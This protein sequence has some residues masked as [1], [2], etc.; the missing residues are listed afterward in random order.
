MNKV[1]FS[2]DTKQELSKIN[3]LAKKDE[4]KYELLGYL[5]SCNA[6]VDLKNTVRYATENEYN[7]PKD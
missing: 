2:Q 1:S 5:I 4:V 7:I 3:N 6:T